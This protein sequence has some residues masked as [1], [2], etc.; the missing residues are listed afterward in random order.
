ME[1][2]RLKQ[3][4]AYST[5]PVIIKKLRQGKII[6]PNKP[7]NKTTIYRFIRKECQPINPDEGLIDVALRLKRELNPCY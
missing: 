6:G 3:E 7:V 2:K 1:V 4:N 5:V